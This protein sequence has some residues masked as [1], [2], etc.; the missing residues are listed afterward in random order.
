MP[1][2]AVLAGLVFITS[3]SMTHSVVEVEGT[4][5]LEPV[6]VWLSI[7]MPTGSGKSALCKYLRKLVQETRLQ[8]GQEEAPFWMLD[9]QSFEKLGE[10][11]QE[12]IG[13]YLDCT[14]SFQCF[15]P[16]L[17]CAGAAHLLIHSK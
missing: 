5:W 14:M 16:K 3:Y 6:L 11:M 2:T 7:C 9:D 8:C 13:S 10:L 17:M 15:C 4:D 1:P 12:T